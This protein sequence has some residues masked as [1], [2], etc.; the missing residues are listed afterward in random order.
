MLGLQ[1][2]VAIVTG[3]G[4]GIG[5]ALT[6]RLAAEGCKVAIFDLKAEAGEETAGIA[7][8]GAVIKTYALDVSDQAAV[9]AA[10]EAVEADL[11]PVWAL[12]NN[13]GWDKPAPFLATDKSLW[14][15][16]IAINLYGPLFTHHAVAPRMVARGGGRIINIASDAARVGT[17]NEAV[18]SACKGGLISFTKS[19]AR[20]LASKGVLLNV[21][22][23]GPT[24]TPMMASVLGEGEQ[25]VKWKDAMVRGIPLKRMGEPEDYAGIVAFLASDDAGFITGQTFS[26]AGGMNMI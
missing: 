17:S 25:A 9:N 7:G 4:Q 3:G 20:E 10:V 22:C 13:A 11:G 12:V 2:K 6:L 14:D 23:P 26:V 18:Y 15:K 1:G 19:V 8:E 21:V 24:N 16:I 5:R